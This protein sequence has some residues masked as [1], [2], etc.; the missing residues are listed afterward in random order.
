MVSRTADGCGLSGSVSFLPSLELNY[1]SRADTD[2]YHEMNKTDNYHSLRYYPGH[3]VQII[4]FAHP[5][6]ANTLI[7]LT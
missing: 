2:W 4:E 5:S 3:V 6:Q 7:T 1:S